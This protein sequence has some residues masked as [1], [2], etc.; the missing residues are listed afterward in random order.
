MQGNKNSVYFWKNINI[1][2]LRWEL[3]KLWSFLVT[4]YQKDKSFRTLKE[5]KN[6]NFKGNKMEI[7]PIVFHQYQFAMH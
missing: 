3:A 5:E 2:H 4:Y 6:L 1:M 7:Y